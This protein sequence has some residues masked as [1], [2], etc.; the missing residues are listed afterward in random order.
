ML[1]V[2]LSL[3]SV[4]GYVRAARRRS[5]APDAAGKG[6]GGPAGQRLCISRV[7]ASA[8]LL[9]LLLLLCQNRRTII[10]ASASAFAVFSAAAFNRCGNRRLTRRWRV[11]CEWP[12]HILFRFADFI[13]LFSTAVSPGN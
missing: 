13:R 8:G 7:F 1:V 12:L 9:M 5:G 10:V 6:R 3:R 2:C 11:K 4:C